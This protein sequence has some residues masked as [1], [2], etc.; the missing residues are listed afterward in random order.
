MKKLFFCLMVVLLPMAAWAENPF[1]RL[2]SPLGVSPEVLA[3]PDADTAWKP[4][5]VMGSMD[6]LMGAMAGKKTQEERVTAMRL[7]IVATVRMAAAFCQKYPDDPRRWRAVLT[8]SSAIKDLAKE[9]GSPKDD[10]PGVVWDAASFLE[11]RKQIE[12]LAAAAEHAPDAPPEVKFRSEAQRPGGLRELSGS[13]QKAINAKQPADLAPLKTEILRLAAKY[14]SVDAV[15]QNASIYFMFLTK[16]ATPKAQVLAELDEFAASPSEPVRKMASNEKDKLTAFDKPL[17]I[18]FTAVDGRKVDLKDYRG[19]VVLVDFWATWCG[20]CKAEIPNIK[21][22]YAEYQA[23]GFEIIGISLENAA[24]RPDDT[25]EQIAAKHEKAQKVLTDFTSKT[26]MPWPQY[27]DGKHW[28]NDLSTRFGIA[29][30]PAMFL[31]DPEGRIVTT[32]ARGP[33]LEAEVKRLLKL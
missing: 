20:P 27:Y 3:A 14:P 32:E 11:F 12:V 9:D 29:S 21:K 10:L 25:P 4:I 18:A 33:K 23:K 28:K 17:E 16:V 15:G 24:I 6:G 22:V 13:I 8:I 5:P 1:T 2:Q 26:E 31:I 19:K 30:I 7:H